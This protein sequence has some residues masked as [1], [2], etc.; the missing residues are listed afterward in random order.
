MFY[1][2]GKKLL[3][4]TLNSQW[5]EK[6]MKEITVE[7]RRNSMH[8]KFCR[9]REKEKGKVKREKK[10]DQLNARAVDAHPFVT[11]RVAE[12]SVLFQ[13]RAEKLVGMSNWFSMRS[14]MIASASEAARCASQEESVANAFHF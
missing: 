13:R 11:A 3:L 6:R 10:K 7:H 8:F 4:A 5:N 12:T 1:R 14:T 2:D 9:R